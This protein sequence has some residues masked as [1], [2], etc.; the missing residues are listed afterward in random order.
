[1]PTVW[2]DEQPQS[3]T[4]RAAGDVPNSP[5]SFC[6]HVRSALNLSHVPSLWPDIYTTTPGR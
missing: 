2:M 4:G 1:M 5:L 6:H 3:T